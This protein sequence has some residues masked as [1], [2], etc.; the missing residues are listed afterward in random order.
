[1]IPA[2]PSWRRILLIVGIWALVAAFF[3]AENA[4]NHVLRGRPIPWFDAVALELVYWVPWVLLTPVLLWLVRRY[5]LDRGWRERSGLAVA[6]VP[7]A[8]VQSV[9]AVLLTYGAVVLAGTGEEAARLRPQIE[10]GIVTYSLT[11]YWK[12][13]AVIAVVAAVTYGRELRE[14]EVESARL[15]T[16]LANARLHAL[17]MR[18]QPHFLFNTLHSVS[19]L[20]LRDAEAANRLLVK[21][22]DLLRTTLAT[23]EEAVVALEREIALVDRYLEIESIRIG[24]R[25]EVEWAVDEEV[26]DAEVPTLILQPLVENAV[27]HGIAPSTAAGRLVVR[28]FREGD[29]LVLEVVDDG[30]GFPEEFDLDEDAGVGLG[31]TK[32][33]VERLYEGRGELAVDSPPSGGARVRIRL[34]F[35][36]Y[37]EEEER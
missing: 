9:V 17:R 14:R 4:A 30:A 18:L 36:P 2:G 12:Y 19:M 3:A 10:L 27:R 26:L 11:A 33:R 31:T 34:P 37:R 20:N 13:W 1:M 16:R 28:A 15:E 5:R 23:A 6:G 25:L 29:D 22:S 35:R 8:V 21:L 24:E 7:V 32:A